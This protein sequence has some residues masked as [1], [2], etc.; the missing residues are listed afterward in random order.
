MLQQQ[1]LSQY[2]PNPTQATTATNYHHQTVQ[3]VG[4]SPAHSRYISPS[5]G[6]SD[7]NPKARVCFSPFSNL[8]T[9]AAPSSACLG[10]CSTW[11][12]AKWVPFAM[13][14]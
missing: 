7:S 3:L 5:T 2:E 12:H 9:Q 1:Q 10:W 11:L 4:L 6:A 8:K 13:C 14:L